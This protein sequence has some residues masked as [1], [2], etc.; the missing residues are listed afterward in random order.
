MKA[1]VLWCRWHDAT[2]RLH[3]R[4]DAAVWGELVFAQE[5]KTFHF[6]FEGQLLTLGQ[7]DESR[8]IRLDEMGVEVSGPD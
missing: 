4:N 8:R 7:G 3:G 5:T 6:E 2:L 1:L